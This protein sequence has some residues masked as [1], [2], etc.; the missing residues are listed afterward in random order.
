MQY[1]FDLFTFDDERL[2]LRRD[3]E[4]LASEPQVLELLG[5][6]LR[7]H[8]RMVS[9]EEIHREVWRG[10]V[11]SD[12]ALSSRIKLLRQLLGDDGRSQHF[13]RT[14][15]KRGFR[16]AGE[17]VSVTEA[18]ASPPPAAK[19]TTPAASTTSHKPAVL[20]LPFANLSGERGQDYLAD[21]ITTDIISHLARHRWL[22]VVARNTAF[23]FRDRAVDVSEV[24]K[25][26]SVEY[27]V[28]GSVQRSA[29]HVRVTVSLL[30][31]LS[32]HSM[33]TE[34][35]DRELEDIFALQDEITE[36]IVARLEP[37][38]GY[39][40]RNRVLTAR[41]TNL[42]AW[43]CFHMGTY[44]FYRFT[45]EDNLEAQRLLRQSRELD[46]RF[47]DA[48]AWW[49][50][51][52]VLGMV[53]WDTEPSQARLD[54]ALAACDRAVSLDRRNATFHAL[55]ARVLLARGEYDVAVDE[56]KRAIALN[57]TLAVAHCA[58]GDSLA[59]GGHYEESIA[60]FEKSIA[61]SPN[62]PQL[63]AFYTYGALALLF[64]G[65]FERA[66]RWLDQARSNP[67][68][69]YWTTAHRVVALAHLDRITQASELAERLRREVPGFSLAF[70]R[71][72]LFYL[73]DPAQIDLYL[74]GL[75][76]SG[77]S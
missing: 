73:N 19:T 38:I 40:E 24:G 60:C 27:V 77:V 21:G 10:R 36:R 25:E 4:L 58:L 42:Q 45:G 61:L 59:Y 76:R 56:N 46:E 20:V 6:L 55:R 14:V 37:E 71:E 51:A 62:D 2:E 1:R 3:G 9:R 12:A 29:D 41:P 57:P 11:V 47:G 34:R 53:Y 5:L 28:E 22:D 48:W 68:H 43:D 54:E 44:H 74:E 49:A 8:E 75:S 63:W 13:I 67:N 65:N 7:H 31:A 50:Y 52:T 15:H 35:F 32:A 26:L 64:M 33:W 39:A 72:K 23:G 18:G 16:F 69:Q 17:R 66:L 70:V 30:D